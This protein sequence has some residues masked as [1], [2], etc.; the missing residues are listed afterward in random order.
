MIITVL[1]LLLQTK[2]HKMVNFSSTSEEYLIPVA[3]DNTGQDKLCIYDLT[4]DQEELCD[5]LVRW[6][7]TYGVLI[8]SIFGLVFNFLAI[9]LFSHKNIKRSFFN[10]LLICL[11]IVD[12]LYLINS[13][14]D[15]WIMAYP[16]FESIA[17]FFFISRPI[18]DVLLCCTIYMV[19][20]LAYERHT[21]F[22]KLTSNTN[23]NGWKKELLKQIGLLILFSVLYKL[24]IIGEFKIE[25]ILSNSTW[26]YGISMIEKISTNHDG[27]S[28][29]TRIVASTTRENYYYILLYRTLCDVIVTGITPLLLLV[30][31]NYKIYVGKRVFIQRRRT[32]KQR[33]I[34]REPTSKIDK[35]VKIEKGPTIT[36]FV[37][38]IMFVVCHISRIVM[39]I[40]EM[41]YHH[42]KFK[43]ELKEHCR[44]T[45]PY[46]ILI[47]TPFSELLLRVN[48]SAN[49]FIY[50]A[51][52]D[53]FRGVMYGYIFK[54]LRMCG[55]KLSNNQHNS[56][57]I[58]SNDRC[59]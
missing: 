54:L 56:I 24:P 42:S 8:V 1:L 35:D 51:L 21:V 17:V 19:V 46:W 49:F 37:I 57:Q 53:S 41:I 18:R 14:I 38:V 15:S 10:H 32:I 22:S 4:M 29:R 2:Q 3:M 6:I 30:Y 11:V 12:I 55:V 23:G 13:I 16:T 26:T 34:H 59:R 36:L 58:I 28:I 7:E 5:I 52:N 50:W 20:M 31:F 45:D 25:T 39:R 47:L 40:A 27:A 48:S 9:I 33:S 43:E 44:V